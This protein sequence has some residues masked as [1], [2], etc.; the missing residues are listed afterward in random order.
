M[1]FDREWPGVLNTLMRQMLGMPNRVRVGDM[2]K[3]VQHSR[4]LRHSDAQHSGPYLF[5]HHNN[6]ANISGKTTTLVQYA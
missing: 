4:C 6:R 1:Q 2:V 3:S 5:D